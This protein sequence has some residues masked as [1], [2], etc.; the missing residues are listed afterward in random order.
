MLKLLRYGMK[1]TA[2]YFLTQNIGHILHVVTSIRLSK[3]KINIRAIWNYTS[4]SFAA[5]KGVAVVVN[6]PIRT[7]AIA[8]ARGRCE[9]SFAIRYS[10][11]CIG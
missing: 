6:P 8:G 11:S 5:T 2:E 3:L 7:I 4:V 1:V 9:T 10:I